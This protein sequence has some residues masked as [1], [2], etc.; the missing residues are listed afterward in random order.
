MARQRADSGGAWR[1]LLRTGVWVA[2]AALAVVIAGGWMRSSRSCDEVWL[3]L[4]K[5]TQFGAE[6]GAGRAAVSL[7]IP[8]LSSRATGFGWASTAL[9]DVPRS[10]PFGEAWIENPLLTRPF[11]FTWVNRSTSGGRFVLVRIQSP[12]WLP[13]SLLVLLIATPRMCRAWARGRRRRREAAD[14]P[15]RR[16]GVGVQDG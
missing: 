3:N 4:G 2:V 13:A 10:W 15:D 6:S 7:M 11:A 5:A 14:P 8:N 9:R 1:R 12:Y 16:P